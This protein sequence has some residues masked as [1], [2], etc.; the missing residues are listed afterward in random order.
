MTILHK[1]LRDLGGDAKLDNIVLIGHSL[2]GLICEDYCRSR[3]CAMLAQ[4]RNTEPV[5][6]GG[7]VCICSPFDGAKVVSL[8]P[9][10]LRHGGSYREAA[11]VM[12]GRLGTSSK[13]RR[14]D[15][16]ISPSPVP[17]SPTSVFSPKR[18]YTN[19]ALLFVWIRHL[20]C[21]AIWGEDW[22]EEHPPIPGEDKLAELSLPLTTTAMSESDI[23]MRTD[24]VTG[25][26]PNDGHPTGLAMSFHRMHMHAVWDAFSGT[27]LRKV[28]DA[29][30]E[31]DAESSTRQPLKTKVTVSTSGKLTDGRHGWSY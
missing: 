31:G 16:S 25:F 27:R 12:H 2:G 20:L 17:R 19:A 4:D 7:V 23:K 14:E 26:T 8:I 13:Q 24:T 1:H 3:R 6:I 15:C 21:M 11:R 10:E 30:G 28:L 29:A 18:E 5:P 9:P 22:K